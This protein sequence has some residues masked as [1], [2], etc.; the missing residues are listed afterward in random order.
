MFSFPYGSFWN[1]GVATLFVVFF[2]VFWVAINGATG[3]IVYPLFMWFIVSYL[4]IYLP[5]MVY[6]LV[7]GGSRWVVK[8]RKKFK[9]PVKLD[10]MNNGR[11]PKITRKKF[12]SQIGIVM[13]SAPFVS[14]LFGVLKG[15]F[16]FNIR[17]S[18][19]SFPNLPTEFDGLRIVQI[20]DLHL[21]SYNASYRELANAVE[22]INAEQP[23]IIC[24]TG[25]LV[26]NFAE[27][28]EGWEKVFSH[29]KARIGKFSIL[30]NHDYGDY[31]RWKSAAEKEKNFQGIVDAHARLGFKL[32]RN[33]SV[34]I[35]DEAEQQYMALVGVENWGH[36]PFPKYGDLEKAS[37]HVNGAPFKVLL[38]H[39]PDH[40]DEEVIKETNYDLTLAGHTHG[41]Q[42]GFEY[43]GLQWSP[44]KYKYRRWAGL[45]RENDQFLYV[46]RGLGYLGMPARLGMPPEITVIDLARGPV[47]TEPM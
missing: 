20:S 26:N 14:L 29:L 13:A 24:F 7:V 17:Y 44:A 47:N 5:K 33:E 25:D 10:K 35:G 2:G 43:L 19:I 41:M 45:Y 16:A 22:L 32:L 28:T 23:D 40:W 8:V 6:A 37:R 1:Y 36:A 31:S 12:L 11:Y 9:T 15:R 4:L 42:V 30:G 27:E 38:S 18:K 39:D 46:N 21:G 34:M 3:P